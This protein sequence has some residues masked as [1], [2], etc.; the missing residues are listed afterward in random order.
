MLI[1]GVWVVLCDCI[2]WMKVCDM[3][4]GDV[5]VDYIVVIFCGIYE[6]MLVFDF[7][8][9]EDSMVEID[10]NFVMIGFGGIVEI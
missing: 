8:Y 10:V 4:F 6:N 5:L 9:D 3:V 2:E 1:I 7:D